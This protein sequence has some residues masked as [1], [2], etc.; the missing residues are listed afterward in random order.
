MLQVINSWHEIAVFWVEND[1]FFRQFF[2]RK[3]FFKILT[4]IP[5]LECKVW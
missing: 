1:Y 4:L 3:Y 2:R 5:G